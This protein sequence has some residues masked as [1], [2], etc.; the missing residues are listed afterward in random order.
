[1][2]AKPL[3][4]VLASREHEKIQLAAMMASV[5][6]VSDRPVEVFVSMD[7]LGVFRRGLAPV[8]RYRGGP[9]HETFMSGKVPDALDLFANGKALGDLKIW[10]CSL[11]LDLN[12]WDVETD[13]EQG[14]FDGPSGLTM[15]LAG[16]ETG[17][18]ITI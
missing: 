11:I 3:Y 4:I 1:M 18:L 9:L 17:E 10:A 5:A 2:A 7:A 12:G 15:F 13:L 16:A 14:L 6:A 8:E